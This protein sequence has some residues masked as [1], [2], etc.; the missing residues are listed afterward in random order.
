MPGT[1]AFV[2]RT[3]RALCSGFLSRK[4]RIPLGTLR[5]PGRGRMP[6][7]PEPRK[8]GEAVRGPSHLMRWVRGWPSRFT[9]PKNPERAGGCSRRLA[10]RPL[11]Y[12]IGHAT[13]LTPLGYARPE[14]TP[15]GGL[16][17]CGAGLPRSTC[18]G[19]RPQGVFSRP[20]EI[21]GRTGVIASGR[22]CWERARSVAGRGGVQGVWPAP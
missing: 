11:G 19:A 15:W 3:H 2:P 10:R 7:C 9:A 18:S 4:A 1:L 6:C 21:P 16:L 13:T 17:R 20:G 22:P 12:T 8:G 5:G 14:A